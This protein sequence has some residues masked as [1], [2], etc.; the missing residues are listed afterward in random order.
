MA[1]LNFDDFRD[2]GK[3]QLDAFNTATSSTAKSLRAIAAEATDYSK[4]SLDN[5]RNYFEKLMRAQKIDDIVQLQSEFYRNAYGDFFARA[6]RVG[7]LCSNLAKEAFVSAQSASEQAT[8]AA[9]EA[10]GKI[11]ADISEQTEK[12]AAKAR[13]AGNGEH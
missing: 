11:V 7:E 3:Y 4:Q 10:T 6:S 9:T 8:K 5:S 2:L 12:L 1:N 13:E